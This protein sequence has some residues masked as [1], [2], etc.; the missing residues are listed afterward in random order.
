V[1]VLSCLCAVASERWL[2]RP[3]RRLARPRA[4]R[5]NAVATP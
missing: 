1:P 3:L 5:A 2:E 4:P